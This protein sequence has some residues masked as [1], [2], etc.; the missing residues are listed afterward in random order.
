MSVP[1][2]CAGI[3]VELI[4]ERV[5]LVY[6]TLSDVRD[7]VVILRAPLVE[8]VPMDDQL[9]AVHVVEHVDNDLVSFAN[10]GE[11]RRKTR[12]ETS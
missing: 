4:P 10:L 6:G 11:E 5:A 8:S 12:F 2:M 7:A 9:Q 1:E 3:G